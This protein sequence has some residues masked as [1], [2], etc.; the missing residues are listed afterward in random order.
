VEKVMSKIVSKGQHCQ[1]AW[2]TLS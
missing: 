2:S 1:N